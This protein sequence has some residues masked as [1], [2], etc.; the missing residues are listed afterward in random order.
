MNLHNAA[1]GRTPY[2]W[3]RVLAVVCLCLLLI[4]SSAQAVHVHPA[5]SPA[6]Q[7]ASVNGFSQISG[8]TET[9]CPLC[10]GLH[11]TLHIGSVVR[12]CIAIRTAA[13]VPLPRFHAQGIERHFA[14]FTRP[15]PALR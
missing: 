14:L 10:A 2:V 9:S 3:A 7:H 1:D 8:D 11:S 12:A 15:P 13:F 5:P 4:T 6:T